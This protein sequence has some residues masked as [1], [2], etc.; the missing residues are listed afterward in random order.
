MV[1]HPLLASASAPGKVE[2]GVTPANESVDRQQMFAAAAR[3]EAADLRSPRNVV[4]GFVG[5]QAA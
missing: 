3:A 2:G 5:R 4:I 1:G